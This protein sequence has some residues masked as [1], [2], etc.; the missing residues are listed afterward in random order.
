MYEALENEYFNWLCVMVVGVDYRPTPSTSY[1]VLLKTLHNTE[2]I[3]IESG[4]D[5]RADDGR[6]LR[7]EY[8]LRMEMPDHPSWRRLPCSVLEMLIAFSRRAADNSE[9][10]PKDWFWEML[11][12]LNLGECN[13]ASGIEPEEIVNV[14]EH[15]MFRNYTRDGDGGLFPLI[16]PHRDQTK[17][18]IWHQFC[19][20]LVDRD[21][22]PA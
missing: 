9:M 2:F 19:D 17:A 14:L 18:Q 10:S 4:D 13:D 12:N 7:R 3:W 6:E 16:R 21:M 15:F 20:Y 1:E 22:L 8:I 5:N 11:R